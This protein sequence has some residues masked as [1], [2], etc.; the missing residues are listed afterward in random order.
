[1]QQ[2]ASVDGVSIA[3]AA[4]REHL[5]GVEMHGGERRSRADEQASVWHMQAMSDR[6]TR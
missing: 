5:R 4:V 2:L 3:D 1:M 6:E